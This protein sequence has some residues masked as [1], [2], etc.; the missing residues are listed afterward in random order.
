MA[1]CS[2]PLGNAL[3]Q[4]LAHFVERPGDRV[5]EP[6]TVGRSVAFLDTP[7]AARGY[8][9]KGDPYDGAALV[10]AIR[11]TMAGEV[12]YGAVVAQLIREYHQRR[13]HEDQPPEMLTPR[14]FEVLDLLVDRKSN[15]EIAELL[16]ISVKT[17][18]THVANILAKLHLESRY[19][20]P[21]YVRTRGRARAAS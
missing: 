11:R 13:R 14:E 9:T 19:E 2:Q 1:R 21:G 12:F 17:V 18:K 5:F 7:A 10:N 15:Q 4:I 6:E 8:I 20:I 3:Q 16:V